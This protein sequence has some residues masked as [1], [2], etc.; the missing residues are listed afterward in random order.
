MLRVARHQSVPYVVAYHRVVE[1]LDEYQDFALP[2]MEISVATLEKHVEWLAQ[3]FEIVSLDEL[4]ARWNRRKA[5]KPLAAI[6]FDDGYSDVFHHALPVLRRNG[7]PAAMFV[8]TDFVG[9]DEIPVHERLHAS[10]A[11]LWKRSPSPLPYL[12]ALLPGTES[13]RQLETPFSATQSI[14]AS[15]RHADVIALIDTLNADDDVTHEAPAALRPMTWD[16]LAALR[17]AGMTIGSHS[18]THAFL[19]N[20]SATNVRHEVSGSRLELQKR[21]GTPATCFAY[22]GGVFN[23]SVVDA[24][25]EAGYQFAFTI[26]RHRSPQHPMLTIPR[27]G[28]WERSCL[29]ARGRFSADIMSCHAAGTFDRLGRC[30]INH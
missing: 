14:L 22:P 4:P 19:T 16:M 5:S 23:G 7:I 20:E 8:V 6:T 10:I 26:C 13:R 3:R 25:R 24:V 15:T 1:R 30:A 29:D 12:M 28:L 27:R 9:T 11:R 17:D 2:A 18:M 21:L